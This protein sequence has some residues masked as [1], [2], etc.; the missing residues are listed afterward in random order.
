MPGRRLRGRR[1]LRSS[2]GAPGEPGAPGSLVR[3]GPP[4]HRPGP[5]LRFR[6]PL[7]APAGAFAANAVPNGMLSVEDVPRAEAPWESVEE[8][9]L[10]Y[11]GY[12]YWSDISEL[13]SRTVRTW[14][15]DG[16]MPE[17][18]DSLRGCLF[19]EARR[20]HH[21]GEEPDGRAEH[22]LRALVDAIARAVVPAADAG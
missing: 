3:P 19:Y 22:Y 13:A 16:T 2:A 4:S 7:N 6:D 18:L 10:T 15:H 9:A 5:V 11:D 14:T 8:F 21:F 1:S 12:A 17:D 20:W